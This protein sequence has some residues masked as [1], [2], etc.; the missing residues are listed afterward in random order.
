LFGLLLDWWE[1]PK[2]VHDDAGNVAVQQPS[3]AEW[4]KV[5]RT[6]VRGLL[7]QLAY[8][9]HAAQPEVVGTADVQEG[10]LLSGLMRISRSPDVNPA[11]LIEYLNSR[12]GLLLPRAPGVYT[13]PQRTF[14]EY[15][16]ACHLTDHEYPDKVVE[17][18]RQDPN[19]WREIALLAG[20]KASRG[21]ASAVWTLVEALCYRDIEATQVDLR[22]AWGAHLAGQVLVETADLT[23]VSERD[24]VK[25]ERVRLWL[26]HILEEGTLPTVERASA[27][28]TLA[29]LG[30]L[31]P[32]IGLRS[33]GLPDIVWCEVPPG[34]FVMGGV[35][36]DRD[37]DG[38]EKPQHAVDLSAFRIG[39]YPVTNAQYAAF[40][41]DGGYTEKW[42][43]CWN[44]AGWDWKGDRTGPRT[45][46]GVFELPNHP[47]VAV[48]WYEAVAFC[49]WLTERSRAV[50]EIGEEQEVALPSEAQWEKAARGTDGRR[51]PW[52]QDTDPN[53]ANSLD[54]GIGS[55]SAVGCF[56]RGASPYGVLDM[57]GNAWEWTRSL[58][59]KEW[60]KPE[61]GYPY[62]S[63][64]GRE[65]LQARVEMRRVLR[66][67]AF[68][69]DWRDIRCA[70]RISNHP[71]REGEVIG[72]RVVLTP[73]CL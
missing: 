60:K 36:S 66:G 58:W 69:N 15:L 13:F 43:Q 22:D 24:R 30:D 27:G 47:V 61:F 70:H 45:Y 16:A 26:T 73:T 9:A 4:L 40:V 54:T 31:R 8:Q 17:L 21:S 18:V 48:T 19:R 32:G 6:Q 51:F 65:D 23:R 55:T 71:Q 67:G 20:A 62:D 41:Q 42:R 53:Y 5:D 44:E 1:Q 37:N 52:G 14:Q 11:R 46:G 64:D 38:G 68:D 63:E 50:G 72:F 3:L 57:A 35:D 56:P 29:R 39:R 7:E 33:D 49:R 25:M 2:V 10:E 28:D 12:A 34:V 59:G